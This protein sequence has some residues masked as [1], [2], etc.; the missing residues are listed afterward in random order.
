M[1]PT[2][3]RASRRPR[4]E[5]GV[6]LSTRLL[7]L[8]VS[9]VAMAALVFVANDPDEVGGLREEA[10]PVTASQTPEPSPTPTPSASPTPEPEPEPEPVERGE[11]FVVIY[12]NTGV[13]GLAGRVSGTAEAAGWNVVGT[14]NWYGTIDGT[15]VYHPPRLRREAQLLARELGIGQVKQAIDP[16]QLDR[17]TVILTGDFSG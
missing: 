4:D 7:A 11:T 2:G 16:M 10:T 5:R 15:A 3:P 14:D 17:L 8:A 13:T 9:A 12:N 6:V 1:S